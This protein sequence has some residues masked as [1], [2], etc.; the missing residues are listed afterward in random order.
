[1]DEPFGALD[2]QTRSLLQQELLSI[3]QATGKTIV[4]VT[5][6]LDEALL[7]ADRIVFMSARPGR[8]VGDVLVDA[9]YPRDVYGHPFLTSLHTRLQD[10]L[11][12]EVA[13][14]AA[15]EHDDGWMPPVAVDVAIGPGEGI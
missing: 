9:P 8:V 14:V 1:M 7:L 6:S 13:A 12:K 3:W 15:A 10:L 4:F 5:H 2:A 11:E